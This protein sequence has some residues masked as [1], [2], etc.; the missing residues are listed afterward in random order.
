[1]IIHFSILFFA[2]I[3]SFVNCKVKLL[4]LVI[5]IVVDQIGP[6]LLSKFENLYNEGFRWLI[7]QG[8]WYINTYNEHCYSDNYV[9]L[10][11]SRLEFKKELN[12]SKE[13]AVDVALSIANYLDIDTSSYCDGKPI[14]L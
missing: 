9:P 5:F 6:Y 4:K 10:I 14:E 11:F 8:K 1:M 13:E 12:D 7:D 2:F 3:L